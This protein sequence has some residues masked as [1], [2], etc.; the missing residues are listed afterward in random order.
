MQPG[1]GS[2]EGVHGSMFPRGPSCTP[3]TQQRSCLMGLGLLDDLV[4]YAVGKVDTFDSQFCPLD[5]YGGILQDN[6]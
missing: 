4:E 5:P 6:K 2:V 1:N 3:F